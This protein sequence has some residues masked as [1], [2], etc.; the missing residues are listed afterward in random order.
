MKISGRE[1]LLLTGGLGLI[2]VSASASEN[3]TPNV[4]MILVDDVGYGDYGCYGNEV[5][6]TPNIDFLAS[7]GVKF[8]D[9][10]S[11]GAV[12]SPT[13]AALMTGR[14]QQYFGI[15]GVV[16]AARHRDYGLSTD[17]NTIAKLLKANNY[18][19]AIYGKWHL[20][21]KPLHN[22]IHFGFDEFVGYVS[23]NVD[24][25]SH[26]DVQGYQDWW[27]NDKLVK[28]E[29]YTTYL[30]TDYAEKY[31]KKKKRQPFFLYLPHE[32]THDPWQGPNDAPVRG[33]TE[34][35]KFEKYEG[36]KDLDTV[37]K[38]MIE[39]LDDCVG[40]V[41]RAVEEAGIADNTLILLFSD[42]GGARLSRNEPLS[43]RKGGLLEGGH[44]VASIAYWPSK[45]KAGTLSSE[46][47]MTMDVLPTICEITNTSLDG[48]PYDGHSF[49]KTVTQGDAM[50]ERTL[51]WRTGREICARN[52]E[53]KLRLNRMTRKG[54]L[55]NLS[56]DIKEKVNLWEK[57]PE[58]VS[59][60]LKEIEQWES[61]FDDI[62]QLS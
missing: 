2:S 26:I 15:E 21:Y 4:I 9:F 23:G 31:I 57:Y 60:L 59:Q 40:R 45:L 24:Y 19:T 5:H 50:P 44:R 6:Q 43:G 16:S 53:W 42:N 58:I 56:T 30:I 8:T 20:G 25:F 34:E 41:V 22:P 39:A 49:W 48:V 13:R 51:F 52:A 7:N 62:K 12:S 29:G 27:H 61:N 10:H 32:A 55:V 3:E 1:L 28:E 14:Y 17:A 54:T 11:N 18:Q 46:T 37:Y 33:Y 47:I 38:E 36:R 35:G